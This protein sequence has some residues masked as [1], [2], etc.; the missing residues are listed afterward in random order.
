MGL[1]INCEEL[2][3]LRLSGILR[4]VVIVFRLHASSYGFMRLHTASYGFISILLGTFDPEAKVDSST[5]V[6]FPP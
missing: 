4:L 6:L 1:I 5:N 3:D 2:D